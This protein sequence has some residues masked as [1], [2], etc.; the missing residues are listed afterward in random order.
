MDWLQLLTAGGAF[1]ALG[2]AVAT[3][4]R[5]R[6][7]MKLAEVQGEAALWTEIHKLQEDARRSSTDCEERLER[8]EKR[9]KA[10]KAE[11][12]GEISLLRHERNNVRQALNAM[13]SMLK[14]DGADV[15]Q[16]I[17][18]IEEM[19]ERGDKVIATEKAALVT[20]KAVA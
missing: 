12:E 8:M 18:A 6:P 1:T 14:R 10:D 20:G 17:A 7:A 13:F 2:V 3:W 4:L 5:S 19:L 15:V 11:L 9:H 16:V